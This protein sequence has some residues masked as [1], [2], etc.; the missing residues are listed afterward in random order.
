MPLL[1]GIRPP[2]AILLCLLLAVAGTTVLSIALT[3]RHDVPQ[4][5]RDAEGAI[6]A[7]TAESLRTSVQTEADALR[8]AVRTYKTADGGSTTAAVKAMLA[9]RP[10]ARGAALFDP[11][12]GREA[13]AGGETLPLAGVDVVAQDRDH[14][15]GGIPARLTRATGTTPRLLFFSRISLPDTRKSATA[16]SR[17]TWLLVLSEPLT[18]PTV[19]GD[20]RTARLVD[21]DGNI[22]NT[23]AAGTAT[24][25]AADRALA[26]SAADTAHHTPHTGD[27]DDGTS[28]NLLGAVSGGHRTL[29]GWAAVAPAG[30]SDDTS[31]LGLTVLTSRQVTSS[32]AGADHVRF[33]AEAAAAL[34][35]IALLITLVLTVTLQRPLLRLHLSAARL[36][37]GAQNLPGTGVEEDDLTRPVP[38][39][40]FGEPARVGRALEA[41]RRQLADGTGPVRPPR[42]RRPGARSVLA[43]CAVL[44]AAWSLPMLFL[45]NRAHAS[46][47][48]PSIV[49]ADQQARTQAAADRVRQSLGQRYTDLTALAGTLAGRSAA[50]DRTPM[51][52]VLDAHPQYRALYVLDRSGAI[53]E[54]V[55]AKPLRTITHTPT[56]SG[57]TTVNTSGRIPSIAAYVQIPPAAAGAVVTAHEPV[58]LFGEID[59]HALDRTLSRPSLG[60]VWLT[61]QRHRVLAANVGFRA[62]QSLPDDRLTKLAARTEGAAGTTGSPRSQVL[63]SGAAPIGKPSVAAATPLAQSGPAAGLDWR[64]VSSRPAASLRLTAY[65]VQWRTMLAGLL[66]LSVGVACLG[67]LHIV[68]VRPLR[69]LATLAELLAGGDRRTVLYPVNHDETGSVTR[70]LELLRQALAAS[71]RPSGPGARVPVPSA[72]RDTAPRS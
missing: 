44:V 53:L 26:E 49:V 21:V 17:R 43:L 27:A 24:P 67:W 34:A 8:H 9:A 66:A 6:A 50:G 48:I 46:T 14:R 10:D 11:V 22:L 18:L 1:G 5:A 52:Q 56:G 70:S 39:P 37:R 20:G 42:R 31:D 58:V 57:I 38:V 16:S 64:V 13:A 3:G 51:R 62:F 55:G 32:S 61:D 33:A 4:A 7:D 30:T 35:A 40:R 54:R 69:S 68:T 23:G 19:H 41:I 63:D 47:T 60:H 29:A 15:G 72:A 28:G 36:V 25:T 2:I 65:Q 45:V 12:T 71:D 59:V